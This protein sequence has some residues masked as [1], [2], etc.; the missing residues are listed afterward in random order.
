MKVLITTSGT[1]S[2]LGELTKHTNKSLLRI[3]KKPAISYIIESYPADAEFVITVGHKAN[4]VK[5]FLELIYDN[6]LFTFVSVDKYEGVGTSL[7]YSMLQAEKYLQQPFIFHACDTIVEKANIPTLEYNWSLGVRMNNFEQYTSFNISKSGHITKFNKKGVGGHLAHIGLVSIKDFKKYW[8]HLKDLYNK[9]PNDSSL[10]DTAALS[11]MI[12][13]GVKFKG[14]ET[15][16]WLDI[17]NPLS[18]KEA[19]EKISDR[20]LNLDKVDESLFFFHDFVVKFFADEKKIKDRLERGKILGKLVPKTLNHKDNFYKYEYVE[21]KTYS[22]V[23]NGEDF[24]NFL[25]WAKKNLWKPYREVSQKNFIQICRDFYEKKTKDRIDKFLKD[26]KIKDSITVINGHKIPKIIDL[27]NK[28]DFDELSKGIQTNFHGDFILENILKTK[29]GYCLLDWRQDFGGLLRSGD[30][31]YDL[32][33]L[34]H[35]LVVNHDIISRNLFEIEISGNEVTCDIMRKNN[36][37][38][39]EKALDKF[40]KDNR[41][42]ARKI[43]ILRA[44][45]WLN[46]SPLHHEPFDKFLYYFGKYNLSK[47][48]NEK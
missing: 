14:I 28:V 24:Y 6:R 8:K 34:A 1:G 25:T 42:N 15:E 18:L 48:I 4:H 35:N 44:I 22:E 40:V 38:E 31:Y 17:G 13:E 11:N 39:C 26:H 21:G 33:K 5:D 47:A 32:S 2:R 27:L 43:K 7:G 41:L 16:N 30:M 46:M 19:R 37:L 3:G 29:K 12:K 45:I 36:L 20:F 10:N 23:A 9:N